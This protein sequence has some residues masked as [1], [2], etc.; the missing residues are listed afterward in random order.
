LISLN[1]A[2]ISWILP[3]PEYQ[4]GIITGYQVTLTGGNS[5]ITT[6]KVNEQ[7][8]KLSS[9]TP[10]TE[11][12]IH[13]M[14]STDAGDGPEAT[15]TFS[16]L[17]G[18]EYKYE[19]QNLTA[20]ALTSASIRA[21]WSSPPYDSNGDLIDSYAVTYSK[22]IPDLTPPKIITVPATPTSSNNYTTVIFGLHPYTAYSIKVVA[23]NSAGE[24]PPASIDYIRTLEAAPSE[25]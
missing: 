1:S 11:Y 6:L 18:V 15:Y 9:L 10:A 17:T 20:A 19:P 21:S 24:S 4:N 5:T 3:L 16:T 2:I 22:L 14:A 25:V 7:Y 8:I 23:V 12:T 13:V